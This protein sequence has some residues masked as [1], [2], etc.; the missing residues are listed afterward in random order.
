VGFN[1]Q[2]DP[3]ALSGIGNPNDRRA[4]GGPDTKIN[5]AFGPHTTTGIGNPNDSA[6][7]AAA[8]SAK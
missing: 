1:P 5:P 7:A 8:L 6:P 3:P 4:L 2:P